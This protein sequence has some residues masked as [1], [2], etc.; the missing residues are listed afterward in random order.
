MSVRLQ[1][2]GQEALPSGDCDAAAGHSAEELLDAYDRV[3]ARP[4]RFS[5]ASRLLA[6]LRDARKTAGCGAAS[7][8][9][10]LERPMYPSELASR[11][12]RRW[13]SILRA[14]RDAIRG[15]TVRQ[16]F[17]AFILPT[18]P[19]S[20]VGGLL[21]GRVSSHHWRID[22]ASVVFF[23]LLVLAS[24]SLRHWKWLSG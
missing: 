7:N 2:D 11:R 21:L 8:S 6:G 19:I 15:W 3:A 18:L 1:P 10:S 22:W 14:V 5:V 9:R 12:L 17:V 16:R 23:E 13:P 4:R 24:W 20:V